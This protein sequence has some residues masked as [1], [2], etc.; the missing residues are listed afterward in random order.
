MRGYG[1]R[2]FLILKAEICGPSE[3]RFIVGLKD[4][5]F[6][7]GRLV[8]WERRSAQSETGAVILTGLDRRGVHRDVPYAIWRGTNRFPTETCTVS[9]F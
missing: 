2:Y 1:V 9:P 7:Y 4:L 5:V 3:R 6:R 8:T